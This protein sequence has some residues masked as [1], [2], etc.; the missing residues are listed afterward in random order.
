MLQ[1][2]L[3]WLKW[4]EKELQVK[5]ADDQMPPL[6]KREKGLLRQ[7]QQEQVRGRGRDIEGC[8]IDLEGR[9]KREVSRTTL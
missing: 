8:G 7:L 9:G 3:E 5:G 4:R 1:A 6:K 2:E